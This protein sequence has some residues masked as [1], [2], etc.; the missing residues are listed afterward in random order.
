M[1]GSARQNVRPGADLGSRTGE[2][3]DAGHGLA[4][5]PPQA[6]SKAVS[7][8]SY[9]GA[10]S[11]MP[12]SLGSKKSRHDNIGAARPRARSCEVEPGPSART[13][14]R[15]SSRWRDGQN[16]RWSRPR[17]P[18]GTAVSISQGQTDRVAQRSAASGELVRYPG[19]LCG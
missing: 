5:R 15:S 19:K 8:A 14:R 18:L 6:H 4:V 1:Q 9:H 11:R 2:V 12:T 17:R 7:G 10:G 3:V 13:P 16:V